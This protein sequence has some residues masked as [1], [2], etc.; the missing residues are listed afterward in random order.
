MG[1]RITAGPTCSVVVDRQGM[2]WLAGKVRICRVP[3]QHK[4]TKL[5][6][7]NRQVMALEDS[8]FQR[9]ATFRTSCK[10]PSHFM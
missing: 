6:S 10:C 1:A 8:L 5:Y 2:Y 9:S 7:G 3:Q 4:L